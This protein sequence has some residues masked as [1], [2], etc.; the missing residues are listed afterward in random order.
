M[1]AA[2]RC[3]AGRAPS[4]RVRLKRGSRACIQPDTEAY[5]PSYHSILLQRE[6]RAYVTDPCSVKTTRRCDRI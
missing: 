6:T 5:K 1:Q 4:R 3:K 2:L